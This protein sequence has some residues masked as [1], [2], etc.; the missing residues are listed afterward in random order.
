MI[1]F[2]LSADLRFDEG[3]GE[4]SFLAGD[5]GNEMG[6]VRSVFLDQRPAFFRGVGIENLQG[7]S[8]V[9][10]RQNGLFVDDVGAHIGKLPEFGVRDFLDLAR[11]LDR[12]RIGHVEAG[13]IGPVLVK[14]GFTAFGE[15]RGADIAPPA[16]EKGDFP[17]GIRAIKA[18]NHHFL[19]LAHRFSDRFEGVFLVDLSVVIEMDERGTIDKGEA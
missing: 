7:D 1:A 12:S 11:I 10:K 13:H 15:I 18:R 17:I 4:R 9:H 16:A 6:L 8:F 14:I 5:A 2:S 19:M 3:Q